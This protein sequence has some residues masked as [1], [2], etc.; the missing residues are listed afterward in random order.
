[1]PARSGKGS[2][3]KF[4]WDPKCDLHKMYKERDI[5]NT[6]L[7]ANQFSGFIWKQNVKSRLH[8]FVSL[9]FLYFEMVNYL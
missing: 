8:C 9:V 2:I 7:F 1:M 4:K 5:S 6:L 3:V